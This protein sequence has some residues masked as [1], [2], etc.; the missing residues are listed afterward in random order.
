MNMTEF[1]LKNELTVRLA[2]FLGI[3]AG[4]YFCIQAIIAKETNVA[5]VTSN[6]GH[7]R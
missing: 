1:L 4:V 3:F 7:L 2:F 6:S 5:T